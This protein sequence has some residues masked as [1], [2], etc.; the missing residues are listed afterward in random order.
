MRDSPFLEKLK[1]ARVDAA[2]APG[3]PV[4]ELP[5]TSLSRPKEHEP[6]DAEDQDGKTGRNRQ[7]REDRRPRLALPRLCWRFDD[8]TVLLR[9]HNSLNSLDWLAPA[10]RCG[11]W[12]QRIISN[13]VPGPYRGLIECGLRSAARPY[14]S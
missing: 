4:T 8:P 14:L 11:A 9:C 3:I 5:R 13:D 7:E 12:G 10:Q 2:A 6:G 1:T